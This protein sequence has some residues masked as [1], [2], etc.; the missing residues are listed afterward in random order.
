M[1]VSIKLLISRDDVIDIIIIVILL[2]SPFLKILYNAKYINLLVLA[3]GGLQLDSTASET[4]RKTDCDSRNG[5][6]KVDQ[7]YVD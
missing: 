5:E 6:K 7:T 4:N 1:Q 2:I 3:M